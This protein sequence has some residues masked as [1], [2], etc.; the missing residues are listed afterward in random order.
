DET[1][2]IVP[3]EVKAEPEL[4]ERIG[5][6]ETFEVDIVPPRLFKRRIVR[7]KFPPPSGPEPSS[8][9]GA[10]SGSF[11]SWR[12]CLGWINGLGGA[13]QIRRSSAAL[14]PGADV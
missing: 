2:E 4:F 5:Q 1:V 10:G 13:E 8:G 3:E 7:P 11:E 14:P 9:A 12:L 6:E